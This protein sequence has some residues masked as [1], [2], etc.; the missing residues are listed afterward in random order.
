MLVA[1][2]QL[3]VCSRP[4]LTHCL[5]LVSPARLDAGTVQKRTDRVHLALV[6]RPQVDQVADAELV[7]EYTGILFARGDRTCR[8]EN[9]T[10]RAS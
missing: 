1:E 6:V 5:A 8:P 10:C 2:R 7:Q 3:M 4:Y 9:P